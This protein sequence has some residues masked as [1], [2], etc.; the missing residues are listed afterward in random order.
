MSSGYAL[1]KE[2]LLRLG[3]AL[4]TAKTPFLSSGCHL[5]YAAVCSRR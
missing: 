1:P 2:L 3:L 5:L 4:L